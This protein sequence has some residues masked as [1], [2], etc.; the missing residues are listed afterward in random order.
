MSFSSFVAHGRA[1]FSFPR[2]TL[3]LQKAATMKERRLSEGR[4]GGG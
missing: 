1:D 3:F 2:S 4:G